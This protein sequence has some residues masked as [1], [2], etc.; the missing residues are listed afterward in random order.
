MIKASIAAAQGLDYL[1]PTL[2]A[3]LVADQSAQ[4]DRSHLVPRLRPQET[5]AFTLY[6]SGLPMKAVA[7]RLNVTH[8]T[9]RG[10]VDR[11]REKYELVGRSARTKV[12]LYQRALADGFITLTP[13]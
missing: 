2:A 5:R 8:D 10:Y 11:V 1:T 9:A 13:P 7:R 6:A 12:Q 3:L 4:A